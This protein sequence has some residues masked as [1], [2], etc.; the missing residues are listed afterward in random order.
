MWRMCE[1]CCKYGIWLGVPGE[2]EHAHWRVI[3]SPRGPLATSKQIAGRP[4]NW[5]T[6][7]RT[8]QYARRQDRTLQNGTEWQEDKIGTQSTTAG[9][10]G[11]RRICFIFLRGLRYGALNN[12]KL[13]SWSQLRFSTIGKP[14]L[15]TFQ[16]FTFFDQLPTLTS[17][18]A[19]K[20]RRRQLRGTTP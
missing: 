13:L 12:L 15:R 2:S 10:P 8:P 18:L 7:I 11:G 1:I 14:I 16:I 4:E 5:K 9:C 20:K 17:F 3:G 6:E 19:G